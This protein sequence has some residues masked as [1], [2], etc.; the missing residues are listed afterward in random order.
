[1]VLIRGRAEGIIFADYIDRFLTDLSLDLNTISQYLIGDLSSTGWPAARKKNREKFLPE[2]F[3]FTDSTVTSAVKKLTPV[4]AH[5]LQR[6]ETV[7]TVF[8]DV[9][10]FSLWEVAKRK[11]ECVR[12]SLN[13]M[14]ATLGGQG[15]AAT[16]AGGKEADA[17]AALTGGN[18]QPYC[19]ESYAALNCLYCY[20]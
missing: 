2:D 20:M 3:D 11:E 8:F 17:V 14:R 6:A 18:P 10:D 1:M 9:M 4:S 12:T 15:M 7:C 5:D 13:P 19:L 16:L